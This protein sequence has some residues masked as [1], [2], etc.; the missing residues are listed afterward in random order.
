MEGV[1]TLVS[2]VAGAAYLAA[3]A[4]GFVIAAGLVYLLALWIYKQ[5]V[6]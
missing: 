4:A 5:H 6:R 3:A 1:T 2:T